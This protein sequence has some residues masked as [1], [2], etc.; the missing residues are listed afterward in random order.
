[1]STLRVPPCIHLGMEK[2]FVPCESCSG[3]V[4]IKTFHCDRFGECTIEKEVEPRPTCWKCKELTPVSK[5]AMIEKA[6]WFIRN[7][8]A[9]PAERFSGRGVVI[10]GGGPRYFA[11]LY[12]S[13]RALRHQGCKLPVEVWYLGRANEMPEVYEKLLTPLGV[14]C[15]NADEVRR[16]FPARILNGWELKVFAI[17][18]SKF[19]EVLFLD[20]DC[21]A[22]RNPEPM[23]DHGPYR[24]KGAIFYC[25]MEHDDRI[26]YDHFAAEKLPNHGSI[27]SGQLIINKRKCWREIN[28]CWHYNDYSDY[29]YIHG[30]GDKHTF[31][32]AWAK[33]KTDWVQLGNHNAW[34]QWPCFLHPDHTGQTIFLHRC[35]DK[36]RFEPGDYLSKQEN[37]RNTYCDHLPM[38][39]ECWKWLTECGKAVGVNSDVLVLGC[40]FSPIPG[41]MNQEQFNDPPW[42]DS[43]HDLASFP[44][45]WADN[46]FR[47]IKGMDF[48]EHSPNLHATMGEL[49]RII[50]P[51]GLL[52]IRF[53]KWNSEF[54]VIDPGHVQKIHPRTFEFFTLQGYG[55]TKRYPG[56][57]WDLLES[58]GAS[59][60]NDPIWLVKLTPHK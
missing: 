48:I 23:F 56:P 29:Y 37:E 10:A 57:K 3:N 43:K 18:H 15:V 9:Y 16:A 31:E 26:H 44:W 55:R 12:V 1:M 33:L 4:K 45:P 27:E 47:L 51:G 59:N 20:S 6:E 8:P 38:E 5:E 24:E 52:E 60:E 41:A 34:W 14:R 46:S 49:H 19:E 54:A 13:I 36:F 25:D 40:G 2:D 32:A 28:L 58:R 30:F 53:P 21:Y 42:V 39:F 22:V 50:K 17:L 11:A 35:R 7:I